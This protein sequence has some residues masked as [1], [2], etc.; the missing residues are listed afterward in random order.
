MPQERGREQGKRGP[1]RYREPS[2]RV[3]N[4]DD[5]VRSAPRAWH[6]RTGFPSL[7]LTNTQEY[8]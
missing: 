6:Q 5:R 7:F 4:P 2:G 1:L 8:M 3:S